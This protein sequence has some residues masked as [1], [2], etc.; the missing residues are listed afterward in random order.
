MLQDAF[1]GKYNKNPFNLQ[2][3]FLQRMSVNMNGKSYPVE[4]NDMKIEMLSNK[5]IP[6]MMTFIQ[7]YDSE[8]EDLEGFLLT[9]DNYLNG[10]WMFPVALTAGN[11]KPPHGL[12]RL[13]I[14]YAEPL[15]EP[16][17]VLVFA[18]YEKTLQMG[19]DGKIEVV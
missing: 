10:Y 9:K 8:F 14:D 2:H 1:N 19:F 16:I 4:S 11:E 3:F 7:L 15:T 17:V 5:L 18:E 6:Y 12:L 13:K